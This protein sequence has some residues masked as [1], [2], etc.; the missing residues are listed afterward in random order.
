MI[1]NESYGNEKSDH[2]Y[3]IFNTRQTIYE[4]FA[5]SEFKNNSLIFR[6]IVFDVD[7]EMN[8]HFEK[9]IFQ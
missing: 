8:S 1:I 9:N 6:R 7:A 3:L 4:F 5:Y 2:I